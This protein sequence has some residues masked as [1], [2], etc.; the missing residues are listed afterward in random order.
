MCLQNARMNAASSGYDHSAR[1]LLALHTAR[2][3]S[4]I[5]GV[6]GFCQTSRCVSR[7]WS[8]RTCCCK[9]ATSVSALTARSRSFFHSSCSFP[10]AAS[11]IEQ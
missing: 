6:S 10:H 8:S 1:N 3:D 5:R 7:R 2:K 4:T 9:A 11:E